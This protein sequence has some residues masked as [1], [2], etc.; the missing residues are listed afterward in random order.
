MRELRARIFLGVLA[1]G[2]ALGGV[3]AAQNSMESGGRNGETMSP[4]DQASPQQNGPTTVLVDP[5]KIYNQ[6]PT[7]WVGRNVTLKNVTVQDTNDSGNFW[8][9]SDSSHRLLI[10]KPKDNPDLRSMRFHK[11]DIVTITG[12]V[13]P[14]SKYEVKETTASQGSMH[15]AINS[16]G[17]FLLA[18]NITITSST[19][20]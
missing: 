1:A 18:N 15:D 8:V 13:K 6:N 3:A 2:L 9:G 12:T 20:H 7:G 11:G 14:A 4:Q 5:G 19:Q 10:V 16:S 17:V